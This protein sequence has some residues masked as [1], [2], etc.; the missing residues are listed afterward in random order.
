M[1]IRTAGKVNERIWYLGRMESGMYLLVVNGEAMLIS[2]GI[3]CI[4]EDV[5]TQMESFGI[6]GEQ[7]TSLL[8]L[9]SHFDHVGTVPYF[10]R[11][12]PALKVYSSQRAWDILT[13]PKAVET[14]NAFSRTVAEKMGCLD[15]LARHDLD[16]RNDVQGTIVRDGDLLK[17]G[18]LEV[19]IMETPGHSLCSISAYIPEVKT[20]LPS[21][22]GGIPIDEAIFPSGNSNYTQ[23]QDSLERLKDLEV[24]YYG[25]D[26][27]GYIV[28]P[29]ARDYVRRTIT[30]AAEL[31]TRIE[32][33]YRKSGDID[34]A[35]RLL[36]EELY[37][38]HPDYFLAP[39]IIVGVFGQMVKHI[40]K[41]MKG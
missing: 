19:R 36:T 14:M 12:Y 39:E 1:R 9:H 33:A 8:I 28:G 17:V 15:V 6:E 31:R 37:T 24:E 21:D 34:R 16:W 29:E 22:A 32:S 5:L 25:A 2:A 30:A 41:A 26:H 18:D 4:L 7:I 3:S 11:K 38:R 20:L 23:Y 40:A 27:Y 35:S 10:R 13:M